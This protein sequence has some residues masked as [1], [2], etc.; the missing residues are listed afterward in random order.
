MPGRS[1]LG[2]VPRAAVIRRAIALQGPVTV[3]SMFS[4]GWLSTRGCTWCADHS[5]LLLA[6]SLKEKGCAD[7]CSLFQVLLPP[8]LRAPKRLCYQQQEQNIGQFWPTGQ[9]S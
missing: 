7:V 2:G 1:A 9:L 5:L 3:S 6:L 4:R 8:V